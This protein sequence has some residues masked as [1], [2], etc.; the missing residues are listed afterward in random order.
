VTLVLLFGVAMLAPVGAEDEERKSPTPFLF[1]LRGDVDPSMMTE[2]TEAIGAISE[3]HRQHDNGNN[4]AAYMPLTG[5]GTPRF[6]IF[7]P[8][9]K[10]GD[11]DGW[12]PMWQVMSEV[13]GPEKTAEV[14]TTISKC[15][16]P[17]SLLLNYNSAVSN[18]SDP[19]LMAPPPFAYHMTVRVQPGANFEYFGMTQKFVE[20]HGSHEDGMHWIGYNNMIGGAGPEIHYFIALD[21][22]GDMDSWPMNAQVMIDSLGQEEWDKIQKRLPEITDVS[23]EIL[24][25][26][27][28]HSNLEAHGGGEQD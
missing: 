12:T 16:T 25:M 19:A 22:L 24:I 28:P 26:S 20:A 9:Q 27:P 14:L 5:D 10:A 7:I 6:H 11:I 21:K 18:P 1:M 3:A 4:W 15:W 8:L 17:E 13:H 23:S 2:Y